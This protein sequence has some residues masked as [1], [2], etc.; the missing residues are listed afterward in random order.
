[1]VDFHKKNKGM[2]GDDLRE[3]ERQEQMA[4]ERAR[5]AHLDSLSMQLQAELDVQE[6]AAQSSAKQV[7]DA[8]KKPLMTAAQ[9]VKCR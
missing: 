2:E 9:K 7:V 3:Q 5:N 1:M 4:V 8:E 6:L